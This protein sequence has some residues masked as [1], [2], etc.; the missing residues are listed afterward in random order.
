MRSDFVRRRQN[1]RTY[2]RNAMPGPALRPRLRN[3]TD[4]NG[5]GDGTGALLCLAPVALHALHA[6]REL[7]ADGEGAHFLCFGGSEV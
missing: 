3:R 2:Y 5:M 1:V 6:G 7:A 4:L